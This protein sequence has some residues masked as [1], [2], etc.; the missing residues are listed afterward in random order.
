MG[1]KKSGKEST[2]GKVVKAAAATVGIAA[3]AYE[4]VQGIRPARNAARGLDS[5]SALGRP[6]LGV[7]REEHLRTDHAA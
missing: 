7:E 4:A 1:K 6:D 2:V 3:M 5:A